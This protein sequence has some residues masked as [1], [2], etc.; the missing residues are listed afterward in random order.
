M[1]PNEEEITPE[2][3]VLETNFCLNALIELLIEKKIFTQQEF[4]DKVIEM[5]ADDKTD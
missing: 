3:L 2:E 4:E 5:G 1:E